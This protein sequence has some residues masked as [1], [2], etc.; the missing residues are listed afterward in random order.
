M[1]IGSKIKELREKNGLNMK[2]F[3]ELEDCYEI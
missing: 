3:S 2:Q 1:L